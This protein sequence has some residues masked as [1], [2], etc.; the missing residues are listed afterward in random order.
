MTKQKK[1]HRINLSPLFQQKKLEYS[2]NNYNKL[3]TIQPI[4]FHKGIKI[5]NPTAKVKC[6][7]DNN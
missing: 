7:T 4:N 5:N 2:K 6:A 1:I 3:K